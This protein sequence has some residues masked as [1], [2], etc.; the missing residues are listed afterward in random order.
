MNEV[1]GLL[2]NMSAPPKSV[3]RYEGLS[4]L[5][6]QA[7]PGGSGVTQI[8]YTAQDF[9]GT[10]LRF[11]FDPAWATLTAVEILN[12][13]Q[14]ELEHATS[15][16]PPASFGVTE[17]EISPT[18]L[19]SPTKL[20]AAGNLGRHDRNLNAAGAKRTQVATRQLNTLINRRAQSLPLPEGCAVIAS[21]PVHQVLFTDLLSTLAVFS[22]C[23]DSVWL[24]SKMPSLVAARRHEAVSL[25]IPPTFVKNLRGSYAHFI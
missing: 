8:R 7:G 21:Q 19:S 12:F 20:K 10:P 3:L 5:A 16:D 18:A 14:I 1:T 22:K 2:H 13:L 15:M 25:L 4:G 11:F 17:G 6:T 9:F 23:T 24:R